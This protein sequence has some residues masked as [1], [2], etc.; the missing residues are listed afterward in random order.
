MNALVAIRA[1]LRRFRAD[2]RGTTLVELTLALS[3]FLLILFGMI[4]YGRLSYHHTTGEK[5]MHL[6]ARVA[7]VRPPACAGV[8]TTNARGPAITTPPPRFGDSCSVTTG[9]CVNPGEVTCL[10]SAANPTAAEIW[11][12]VGSGMPPGTT[13]SNLRFRY[14]FDEDL[15][16]LGGPY[17]PMVTVELENT[18]FVFV[19][20][21]GQLVRLG[22]GTAP[23]SLG[24]SIT[25][26]SFSVSMP[27]EDLAQGMDG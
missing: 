10:G 24:A 3:C 18:A 15:G 11:G 17:V 14:T 21:L 23:Q 1:H 16:F 20:P 25:L 5:A 6:V 27:A 7:V 12:L 19:S 8:P 2:E 4:D 13:I 22:G 9:A 26:P